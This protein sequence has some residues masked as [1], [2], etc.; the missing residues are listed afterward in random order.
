MRELAAGPE[1]EG[2]AAQLI[3]VLITD[4]L[5][6][7]GSVADDLS[8]QL[9]GGAPAFFKVPS[10]PPFPIPLCIF[11]NADAH[12]SAP[13]CQQ[14]PLRD[15]GFD[16]HSAK[17]GSCSTLFHFGRHQAFDPILDPLLLPASRMIA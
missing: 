9:Q 8:S 10:F 5:A 11:Y 13:S 2:L 3:S 15:V 4:H 17:E 1:G 6:A 16:V 14:P 7:P 12:C